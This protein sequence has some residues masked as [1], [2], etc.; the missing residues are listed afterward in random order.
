[1][2]RASSYAAIK[3]LN[4]TLKEPKHL[5]ISKLGTHA[6]N[7][8]YYAAKGPKNDHKMIGKNL[9][10]NIPQRLLTRTIPQASALWSLK[11][12]KHRRGCALQTLARERQK[13]DSL[14]RN[15]KKNK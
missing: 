1:M 4:A 11:N 2:P 8:Q 13:S 10:R 6:I 15:N 12:L 7:C 3:T 9:T 5:P 14:K